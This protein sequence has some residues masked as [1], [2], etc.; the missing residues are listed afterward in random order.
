MGSIYKALIIFSKNKKALKIF[1]PGYL[2]V[3][4]EGLIEDVY[5]KDPRKKY[6]N[7]HFF[8][9]S[10]DLIC[11]GFV[12]VHNHLPQYAFAGIGEKALLPWLENNTFPRESRFQQNEIA[13]SSAK[14]FFND[15]IRNGTTTSLTYVTIHKSAT[16]LAF[17]AAKKSGVR[18]IIGKVMM[19]QNSPQSLTEQIGKS[20][21]E[22]VELIDKW[23][24][25]DDR[26]FYVLTPRFAITCS[27]ELMKAIGKLAKDSGVYIQTHL[28]E[29]LD[30]IAFTKKLFPNYKNYTD[31]YYRAGILGPRTIMAHCIHLNGKEISLIKRT[32]T[33]I[34]HCPTSNRFLMSGI[35]PFRSF[36]NKNLEM[37]LGTDVAGGYSLSMFNEMKEAIENSKSLFVFS[38][39]EIG[40]PMSIPE[41]FYLATL[42][43]AEVLSMNDQIGSLE[44]GKK[45]DFLIID[46]KAID[47]MGGK[48]DYQEPEQILS[49]LIYRGFS[50]VIKEV[51]IG[52][53][54]VSKNSTRI[55]LEDYYSRSLIGNRSNHKT[56]V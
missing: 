50:S 9:R 32:K 46:Y 33:K 37:G 52:G 10:D 4:G 18:A 11:P 7:F 48:S 23:H 12:D 28:S 40:P 19:N 24:G 53:K 16:D 31:I 6:K 47:P 17:E 55:K 13:K 43:G 51:F 30:E 8:D 39:G 54:R 15:L 41:A 44:K 14:V 34:A 36:R 26:L 25:Y 35:M 29:N 1:N 38:K 42:G 2:V 5:E 45:A 21:K 22:S 49:K 20:L 27:W 3:S 56:P